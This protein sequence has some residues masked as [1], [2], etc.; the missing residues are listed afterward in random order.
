MSED[1]L[2]AAEP[3]AR[4]LRIMLVAPLGSAHTRRW[5]R[6][7]TAR[8]HKITI[9]GWPSP[10]Q[11]GDRT[12]LRAFA[13]WPCRAI[14]A[15]YH[16]R[17]GARQS[18]PDIIH[19]HSLGTHALL[20]L[21]LPRQAA[22]VV[23]T[24]WGSEVRAAEHSAVRRLI[25]RLALRRADLILPTSA[26]V[27]TYVARRY[28]PMRARIQTLSWGVPDALLDDDKEAEPAAAVRSRL[29]LPACAEVVL[30]VRTTSATYRTAE[31]VS[32]F[33]H[34]ASTRPSLFLVVLAGHRPHR[35]GA[36]QAQ[37]RYLAGIRAEAA[38]LEG[39]LLIIDEVLSHRATY[40]LM[41]AA[42]IAISVPESDQRSSSVLESA[43]AGCRLLLSDIAPYREMVADGLRAELLSEPLSV[44]LAAALGRPPQLVQDDQRA[45]Q[46]FIR[47]QERGSA[48]LTELEL[49]YH[50]LISQFWS[51]RRAGTDAMMTSN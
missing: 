44:S 14:R 2:R 27:A 48:K 42:A 19:I 31:I 11:Q 37:E 26:E 36:Q 23:I 41:C 10:P 7:L 45:N 34:A 51:N 13:W 47:R 35:A 30:S 25:A 15:A 3:S 24:P 40:D 22:P 50:K 38:S 9:S 49:H 18:E 28:Y 1:N 29:E 20:A 4:P 39:R 5:A 33:A 32:A 6:E 43:L 8:G 21:A 12:P 16:L 17:R 46:L